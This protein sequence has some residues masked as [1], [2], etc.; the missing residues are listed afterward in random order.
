MLLRGRLTLR[1]AACRL[2]CSKTYYPTA[3]E[4]SRQARY[5]HEINNEALMLMASSGDDGAK[6]ERLTREV[7]FVDALSY[8]DATTRVDAMAS[9]IKR[10]HT[11]QLLSQTVGVGSCMVGLGSIPMVFSYETAIW[12]N[13]RFV[14]TD[15]PEARDLETMLE[16]GQWTWQ[17]MEPP[18]GTLSFLFLAFQFARGRGIRNPLEAWTMREKRRKLLE[19]YPQYSELILLAWAESLTAGQD[20]AE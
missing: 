17:W 8:P 14:T 20:Y 19:Q 13:E 4:C 2:L 12:F 9:E 18:I 10:N 16:V 1:R 11:T 15:V 6:K 3:E 7:M 5:Y